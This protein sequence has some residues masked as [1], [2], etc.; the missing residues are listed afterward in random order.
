MSFEM[1]IA[2]A[3][4]IIL[5]GS[6]FLINTSIKKIKEK[7]GLKQVVIEAGKDLEDVQKEVS[8]YKPQ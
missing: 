7:G 3:I 8:G 5:C 6:V 1:K 4:L 2:I